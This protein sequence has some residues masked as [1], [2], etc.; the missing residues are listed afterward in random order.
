MAD[1]LVHAGTHGSEGVEHDADAVLLNPLRVVTLLGHRQ[2]IAHDDDRQALM[3]GL[4]DAARSGFADEEVA[5]LH[6]IADL[7]READHEARHRGG[8]RAQLGREVAIVPADH[9]ELRAVEAPRDAAHRARPMAAEQHDARGTIRVEL[10]AAHLGATVHLDRAVELRPDDHS[11]RRMHAPLVAAQRA[12]LFDRLGRTA[13]EILVL[14]G[15]EPEMRREI[16]EVRHDRRIA[17]ARQRGREAFEHLAIEVRHEGH[18][19]IGPRPRPVLAQLLDDGLVAQADQ[20]L[21]QLELLGEAESPTARE[22]LVVIVLR[23]HAGGLAKHA[24]RIE[25]FEQIHEPDTPGSLLFGDDRFQGQRRRS[26]AAAGIDVNEVDG[27][28]CAYSRRFTRM[29]P[30]GDKLAAAM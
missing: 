25:H 15:F 4:A 22:A 2:R 1:H 26:M 23:I 13:D 14:A 3:H 17:G 29:L 10:Q 12:R 18:D 24:L 27:L 16:G 30:G 6:V 21:E 19:E 20:G 9:D 28:Q 7:G 8:Q 11:G 5:E